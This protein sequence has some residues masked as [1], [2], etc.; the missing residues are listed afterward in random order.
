MND[1]L[2]A[3]IEMA[4]ADPDLGKRMTQMGVEDLIA[5]AR[6]RGMEL[7]KEDFKTPEGELGEG[8]LANVAGGFGGM[9]CIFGAAG[10]RDT[11]DGNIYGC[12]CWTYGQGGDG[13]AGDFNCFCVIAGVGLDSMDGSNLYLCEETGSTDNPFPLA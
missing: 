1:K 11:I 5:L 6:E 9:C 13:R 7:S 2:K 8:D 3:F 10:G 4:K 12:A